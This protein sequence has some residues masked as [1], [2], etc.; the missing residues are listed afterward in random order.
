MASE[1][2]AESEREA[3]L[4]RQ[5]LDRGVPAL[6]GT[7]IACIGGLFLALFAWLAWAQVDE[8]VKAVGTVQP[9]GRVKIVNHPHGGRVAAI[10][11]EEGQAVAAGQLLIG[12]DGELARS[13]RDELIGRLERRKVEVARLE[14]EAS[15]REMALVS[16][17]YRPDLLAAQQALLDARN[18]A[19]A[20]RREAL[21]RALQTRRGEMRTAA[22]EV[23][24]LQ[25]SLEFLKRQRTA[26]RELADRGLYPEL[27]VV[28]L[29]RQYSDDMGELAKAKASRDAA[30]AAVAEAESRLDGLET[31]RRSDA[32]GQ[33]A[34]ATAERDRLVEQ[35]RAQDAILAN[36]EIRAPTDGIVQEIAVAAPGQSVAPQEMLM[37]LVPRSDGLVVEAKVANQDVGRL[38]AGMPAAVKVR[39]FD[40]LRYGMLDGRLEKIAAD[41]T[42]D[43][44]TGELSYAVTVTTAGTRLGGGPDMAAVT[45][46][47]LVDVD[48]KV[49]ERTV[50]SYLTDRIFRLREAFR[51]G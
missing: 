33:L 23:Q 27:K 9:A 44:R 39:A 48:L 29:E 15:G 51:E 7:L 22:A 14:A 38:R 30:E 1:R 40:Y 5:L 6:T 11:V 16:A 42:A 43:P 50:L 4:A 20:D 46:G 28:Q 17:E 26:V 31:E 10:L 37:K 3:E 45:P 8:V 19:L 36:L 25:A 21:T 34:Q 41:A 35:L 24:R 47:M 13:E 2:A 32:L 49:G 12:L 18:A